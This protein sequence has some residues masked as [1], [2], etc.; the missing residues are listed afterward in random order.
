MRTNLIALG[1]VG[2]FLGWNM[3]NHYPLWGSFH[4]E[5]AASLGLSLLL[6]GLIWPQS[7]PASLC[8]AMPHAGWGWLLV[9][10]L[11]VAQFLG[12]GLAFRGDAALGL[13]Y[14]LGAMLGI[15]AGCL[16]A[17]QAG[18]DAALRWLWTTVMFGAIAAFAVA[19]SQWL[20]IAPGGW[21]STGLILTRPFGN[22][23]QPNQFGLFMVWGIVASVALFEMHRIEHRASLALV[24]LMFGFGI[25]ISQS[26]SALVA[27][28]L[29]AALWFV[30]RG[31]VGSRLRRRDVAVAVAAGALLHFGLP[32]IEDQLYLSVAEVRS[33]FEVGPREAIWRHFVAAIAEH[34]WLGYGFGQGVMALSE[35]A[36]KVAPSRN[37]IYAHNVVLD[38]ATWYGVPVALAL[39]AAFAAWLLGWLRRGADA[40][41]DK[42]RHLAFAVWLA[43]VVQ[44]LLEY[45]FAYAYFLLPAAL[46]AGAISS[47]PEG[48]DER[49]SPGVRAAR[50]VIVLAAGAFA[51]LATLA[52]EYLQLEDDFRAARFERYGFVNRPNHTAL[53]NP[54]VLDQLAALNASAH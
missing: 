29:V 47:L 24:V 38:L 10:L 19:F 49:G 12:G 37:T 1:L 25:A 13:L 50:W 27:I 20:H 9:A 3:P 46:L 4:G 36:T 43:L 34:P 14:G 39:C 2:L 40:T 8:L 31:H 23:G 16:W 54:I 30:T 5:L 18:R 44:S 53:T 51:L 33:T 52:W 32:W 42:Q 28:V 45:P 17:A 6:G 11:P 22:F 7:E 41:L 26:R 35:V 15:Y 48:V 21:W